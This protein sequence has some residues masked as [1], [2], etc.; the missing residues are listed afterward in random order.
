MKTPSVLI[1][2]D[3]MKTILSEVDHV[4]LAKELLL[5]LADKSDRSD[6]TTTDR[7]LYQCLSH[8]ITSNS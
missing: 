6:L 7:V 5:C 2:P 1:P 4:D 8:Y 3:L